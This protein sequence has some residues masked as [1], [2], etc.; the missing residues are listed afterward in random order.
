MRASTEPNRLMA[1][2]TSASQESASVMSVTWVATRSPL[3]SSSAA[4]DSSVSAVRAAR[5]TLAPSRRAL[6]AHSRPRPPPTPVTS[7]VLP[8]RIIPFFYLFDSYCVN[9]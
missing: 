8:W 5:T 3:G 4:V 1:V 7:T 9:R 2:S 6:V